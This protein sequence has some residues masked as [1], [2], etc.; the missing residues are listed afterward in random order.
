[1]TITKICR[2]YTGLTQQ[3]LSDAV[4]I[5]QGLVQ[6]IEKAPPAPNG[7][8]Y[9][10]VADYLGLP[11]D[12][13]LRDNFTAIPNSF[14]DRWPQ[15]KYT[16]VPVEAHKRI[17]REGEEFVL[18][19]EQERIRNRWPTLAKLVLPHFKM[20]GKA[21]YDILSFD[22]DARPVCLEVKTSIH[23]V[24]ANGLHLTAKELRVAQGCMDAG[25]SYVLCS[26]TNWGKSNQRRQDISFQELMTEY[27]TECTGVRFRKKS[28]AA[29]G[30]I[31]GIAYHRKRKGLN[32]TQLAELTGMRQGNICLYE[33]G[34]RT[35]SLQV[36][37]RLSAALD[38]TIDELVQMYEVGADE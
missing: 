20:D 24:P 31:S 11:Y 35:P 8:A 36:L 4:G 18:R 22:N 30:C 14:F 7:T 12:A 10:L 37:K 27:E 9:K 16:S 15:P 26:I 33:R 29:Q 32:Q 21:G 38:A 25:E 13:V 2:L 5:H 19:Q 28:Y 6:D 23:P 34:R 17:G 1:M 3:A